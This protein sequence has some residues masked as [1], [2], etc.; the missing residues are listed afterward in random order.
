[1]NLL[2]IIFRK[3]DL[4]KIFIHN[5]MSIKNLWEDFEKYYLFEGKD[6]PQNSK[7]HDKN[8]NRV[9]VI[10]AFSIYVNYHSQVCIHIT[11]D[12]QL[13]S[14]FWDDLIKRKNMKSL[15]LNESK[16]HDLL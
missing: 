8:L 3:N 9:D 13:T 12:R 1:M 14:Y 2:S 5:I 4:N 15:Y 6:R 7:Y 10:N 11:T 16:L